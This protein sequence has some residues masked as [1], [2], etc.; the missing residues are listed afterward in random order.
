MGHPGIPATAPRASQ[1]KIAVTDAQESLPCLEKPIRTFLSL[2]P[3]ELPCAPLYCSPASSPQS[4]SSSTS[5]ARSGAAIGYGYFRDELYFLV[6]AI[7]WPGLRRSASAGR[8]P[9]AAGRSMLF[10][11]SPHRHSHSE[12]AAAGRDRWPH[13]PSRP[14]NSEES[15]AA[16]ALAMTGRPRRSGLSPGR[17]TISPMNA[18]EPIFWMGALLV[19]SAPGRGQPPSPAHGCVS[20]LLTASASKQGNSTVFLFLSRCW[21]PCCS[22]RRGNPP[23]TLGAAR[24]GLCA[25]GSCR[26]CCGSGPTNFPTY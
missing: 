25:A 19:V 1:V 3:R 14:A 6:C 15:R 13:R 17:R 20:G 23:F 7:I 12:L 18:F 8:A 10:G 21:R 26:T 22:V 4:P 9:G 16:Q 24:R 11:L 5:P 2:G